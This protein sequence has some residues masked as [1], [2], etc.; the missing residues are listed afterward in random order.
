MFMFSIK[1]ENVGRKKRRKPV[2]PVQ[3]NI[4]RKSVDLQDIIQTPKE[5]KSKASPRHLSESWVVNKKF[6]SEQSKSEIPATNCQAVQGLSGE[7]L[8]DEFCPLASTSP[9][10]DDGGGEKKSASSDTQKPNRNRKRSLKMDDVGSG[11]K[12]T[13]QDKRKSLTDPKLARVPE[14]NPYAKKAQ[15]FRR[16][17]SKNVGEKRFEEERSENLKRSL[18][19]P[20]C[21]VCQVLLEHSPD[22]NLAVDEKT[23]HPA[24][25]VVW[26]PQA[27]ERGVSTSADICHAFPVSKLMVCD[28]CKVCVHAACYQ[29]DAPSRLS[30]ADWVCDR[31]RSEDFTPKPGASTACSLCNNKSTGAVK[32]SSINKQFYHIRCALLMPEITTTTEVDLRQV[33]RRRWNVSCLVCDQVGKEPAVHCRASK[34]CMLSFHPSCVFASGIDCALGPENQVI[35]RCSFCIDKFQLKEAETKQKYLPQV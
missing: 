22:T 7:T 24:Q 33:P 28:R 25:S 23:R 19:E 13:K 10:K 2:N 14:A 15:S 3:R 17:R 16:D 26:M 6:M 27:E 30:E 21:D 31:C 18:L 32:F 8:N 4:K 9:A 35:I 1:I 5:T 12:K 29:V 20:Y 34:E 11:S